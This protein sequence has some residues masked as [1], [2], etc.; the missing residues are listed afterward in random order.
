MIV[1]V[2][3]ERKIAQFYQCLPLSVYQ[4]MEV[5]GDGEILERECYCV[6]ELPSRL[7]LETFAFQMII[8]MM[9]FKQINPSTCMPN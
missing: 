1:K 2:G 6:S 7:I 4:L 3:G 9:R 8:V 5:G